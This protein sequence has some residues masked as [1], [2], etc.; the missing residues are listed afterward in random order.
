MNFAEHNN[1]DLRV[2]FVSH[3]YVIGVNQGKL[4]AISETGSIKVGLVAP[5]NWISL[6]WNRPLELETPHPDIEIYPTPVIFPGRGGACI[7]SPWHVW[8]AIKD[9]SPDIIQVELEAFSLGA[10][11]FALWS[12][13]TGIPVVIFGWENRL[14][15]RLSFLRNLLCQYVFRTIPAIIPGNHDGA[16]LMRKWNYTGLIETIPQ[17]GVDP[18]FFSQQKRQTAL[19]EKSLE[20]DNQ[21]FVIGY[22]GRLVHEKG[23][24]VVFKALHQLRAQ[25]LDCRVVLWGSG[26][27]EA[28]LKQE[29]Q[30]LQISEYV[31]WQGAVRHEQVPEAISHFDALVLPSRTMPD[32]KE[33]FGHVLIEAMA[34]GVPVV[35]SS[36]GEIPHV[37]GRE[38]LV[39]EE[40]NDEELAKIIE[41][42]ICSPAWRE[43]IQQYGINRV[44]QQ[45]THQRIAER[46]VSLWQKILESNKRTVTH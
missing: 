17:M 6:E 16:E 1:L 37:I 21:T 34:M 4:K 12:N 2:L 15:R 32:W 43:E 40:D 8:K 46:L 31:S 26:A 42:L 45:F 25:G 28:A 33:Q 7:Y 36:S 24:D 41:R 38:D 30:A 9:F 11:E 23:V 27:D 5:N 22:L 29:A 35:G 10:F 18:E 19:I 13:A 20:K 14:D 39:F 3:A 44:D